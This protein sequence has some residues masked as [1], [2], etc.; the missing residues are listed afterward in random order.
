[1]APAAS[2]GSTKLD[3][4]AGSTDIPIPTTMVAAATFAPVLA[5][6][7]RASCLFLNLSL[8]LESSICSPYLSSMGTY[9]HHRHLFLAFQFTVSAL[10]FCFEC[11]VETSW[12]AYLQNHPSRT[13]IP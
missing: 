10:D 11:Q 9:K 7:V 1:M 3:I 4:D 12:Q 8:I 6:A 5:T 2:A 13:I